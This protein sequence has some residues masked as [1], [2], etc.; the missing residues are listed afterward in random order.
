MVRG[1]ISQRPGENLNCQGVMEERSYC[2]RNSG[3]RLDMFNM[4]TT[5]PGFQSLSFRIGACWLGSRFTP[6]IVW[7]GETNR[8]NGRSTGV[9]TADENRANREMLRDNLPDL[10]RGLVDLDVLAGFAP[11]FEEDFS[12]L[13][14]ESTTIFNGI[15]RILHG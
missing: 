11:D 15:V 1:R 13:L 7:A 6:D 12:E 3:S 2:S 10:L 8:I 4:T 5:A 9:P 14:H